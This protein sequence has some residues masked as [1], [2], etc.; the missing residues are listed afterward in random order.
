MSLGPVALTVQ[1]LL[2]RILADRDP[3]TKR[4]GLKCLILFG[5]DL[6]FVMSEC[7]LRNVLY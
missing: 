2:P 5:F 3:L 1:N 7:I 6:F 4:T